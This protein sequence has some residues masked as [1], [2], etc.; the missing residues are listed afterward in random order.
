MVNEV[1]RHNEKE[2]KLYI[3][4]GFK[5]HGR[6]LITKRFTGSLRG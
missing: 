2:K 1:E 6:A 5:E 3:K 4:K